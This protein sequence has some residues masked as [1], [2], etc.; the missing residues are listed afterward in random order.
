MFLNI[1]FNIDNR[2]EIIYS[3]N[4]FDHLQDGL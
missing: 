4:N 2:R 1:L 3:T